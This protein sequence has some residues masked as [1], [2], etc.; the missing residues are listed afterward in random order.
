MVVK[1]NQEISY[2]TNIEKP[3]VEVPVAPPAP[4]LYQEAMAVDSRPGGR[5]PNQN[6]NP[7]YGRGNGRRDSFRGTVVSQILDLM[8]R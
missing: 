6:S 1:A 3:K 8:T 5:P 4:P 7:G 2:T